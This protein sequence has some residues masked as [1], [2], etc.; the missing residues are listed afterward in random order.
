MESQ[1]TQLRFDISEKVRLHPHQP[2]IDALLELDLYPDVEI[3]DEGQHL[4]IQGYLRLN[5]IYASEDKADNQEAPLHNR[6]REEE[7][8][9]LAYV[10]PVEITLPADRVERSRISAEVETFDYEVLSPFELQIEAILMIDGLLPEKH[11]EEEQAKETEPKYPVFSGSTAQPLTISQNRSED[12]SHETPD[13]DSHLSEED[14]GAYLQP[15]EEPL[16]KQ[17]TEDEAEQNPVAEL[18]PETEAETDCA[19]AGEKETLSRVTE[20]KKEKA[21]QSEVNIEIRPSPQDFRQDRQ[22]SRVQQEET[23]E[24]PTGKEE[25]AETEPELFKEEVKTEEKQNFAADAD[26]NVDEGQHDEEIQTDQEKYMEQAESEPETETGS[27]TES[28][29]RAEWI[30]WLVKEK[31]E[32]FVPMRMVIVQ[33]NETIDHVASKYEVSADWLVKTNRL[34]TDR[35]EPG[36]ILQVPEK[37]SRDDEDVNF[38]QSS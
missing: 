33:E 17:D 32:H 38:Q 35:I 9:E 26:T 3:K 37:K 23:A 4:K 24:I 13:Q 11:A 5:G 14:G 15:V 18:S 31:E 25:M 1:F 6:L 28:D 19:Q 12:H 7:T 22:Q 30:R 29:E 20:D 10:I 36:Q 21:E 2:G 34:Q 16:E 8:N 27:E